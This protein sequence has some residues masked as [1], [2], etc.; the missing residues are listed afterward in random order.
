MDR[1]EGKLR[2]RLARAKGGHRKVLQ[3]RLDAMM[4]Q[5]AQSQPPKAVPVI[6][7]KAAKKVAK[8][9]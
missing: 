2:A 8:K 6:T 3:G 1:N 7:K 9:K 5:R 4:A